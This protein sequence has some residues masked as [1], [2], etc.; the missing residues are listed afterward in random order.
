MVGPEAEKTATLRGFGQMFVVGA[1]LS[2]PMG[3]VIL[4]KACGLGAPSDGPWAASPPR[5]QRRVASGELGPM[6]FDG[7]VKLGFRELDAAGYETARAALLDELI[8]RAVRARQGTQRRL[9][10]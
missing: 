5:R 6:A 7:A 3:T 10:G 8:A 4:R 1:N 2:V 9:G